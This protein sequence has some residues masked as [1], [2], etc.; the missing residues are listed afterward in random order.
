[1]HDAAL[2]RKRLL[3]DGFTMFQFSSYIRHCA[4]AENAEVHKK[5]VHSI[6][7]PEGKVGMICLTDKQFGEME[8]FFGRK[9]KPPSA[10]GQQLE[11]F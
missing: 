2:F 7:P 11:L 6:L 4:S 3:Q 10:P 5:R 1:M 9:P 8:L